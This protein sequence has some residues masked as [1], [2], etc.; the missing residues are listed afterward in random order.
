MYRPFPAKVALP[1]ASPSTTYCSKGVDCPDS[2]CN[3][4]QDPPVRL[5][6]AFLSLHRAT[7]G[8]LHCAGVR[9]QLILPTRPSHSVR[10]V[11]LIGDMLWYSMLG[12]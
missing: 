2:V 7:Y 5:F 6:V 11:V 1:Y 8:G 10:L 9:K 4:T 12:V 3:Y